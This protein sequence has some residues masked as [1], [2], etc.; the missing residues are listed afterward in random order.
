M[1]MFVGDRRGRLIDPPSVPL[2]SWMSNGRFPTTL[3]LGHEELLAHALTA[4]VTKYDAMARDH[5]LGVPKRGL[6]Q[7]NVLTDV[8]PVDGRVFDVK[9][10]NHANDAGTCNLNV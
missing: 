6:V 4:G 9:M 2:S 5:V 1:C 8:I 10:A 3:Q 7:I